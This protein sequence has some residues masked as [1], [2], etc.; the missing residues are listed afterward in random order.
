MRTRVNIETDPISLAVIAADGVEHKALDEM[1]GKIVEV[2]LIIKAEP[3]T[4]G[5]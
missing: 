1:N 5:E 3:D 4:E 2:A